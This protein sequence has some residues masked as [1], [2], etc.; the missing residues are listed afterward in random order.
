MRDLNK[1]HPRLKVAVEGILAKMMELGFPMI[2][3]D[4]LR[5]LE[6]QQALYA[7]GRTKPGK[8]VTRA[9]G[10]KNKSNHQAKDDGFAHAVDMCFLVGSKPSWDPKLPWSKYG[11][12]AKSF[13]LAW[14]GDWTKPDLPHIELPSGD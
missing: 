8:I 13:G 6:E 1:V 12:V 3:T 5:T 2:V 14:G 9:D 10:V 11:E 4:T 7:Q